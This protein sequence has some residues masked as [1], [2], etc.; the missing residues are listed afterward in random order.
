MQDGINE[1][2]LTNICYLMVLKQNYRLLLNERTYR[3]YNIF[4]AHWIAHLATTKE[5][6]R[7]ISFGALL[8]C[9]YLFGCKMY[10]CW[11]SV[12]V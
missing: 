11:C 5:L 7:R 2:D 12:S 8:L 3:V 1:L 4:E 10:L 6:Q 9:C